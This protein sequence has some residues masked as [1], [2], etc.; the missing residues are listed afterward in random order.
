MKKPT[1]K[2]KPPAPAVDIF[3]LRLDADALANLAGVTTRRVN[4]LKQ[5]A[6]LK[7]GNDGLYS[8]VDLL[9]AFYLYDSPRGEAL[10]ARTRQANARALETEQR[11]RREQRRLLTLDEVREL[12][13]LLFEGASDVCQAQSARFF[14][15]Y[16]QTHTDSESRVMTSHLYDPLR[17]ITVGWSNGVAALLAAIEKDFLPDGARLDE[18]MKNLMHELSAVQIADE[19]TRKSNQG[20]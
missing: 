16:N 10:R 17:A 4:Q 13:V 14:S 20:A 12:C 9:K 1:K 3:A 2:S 15:E 11:V 8:A 7:Q 19:K 18:V 5:E 6:G